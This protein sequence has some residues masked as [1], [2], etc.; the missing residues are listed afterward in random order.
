MNSFPY[1]EKRRHWTLTIEEQRALNLGDFWDTG[2]TPD[3]VY[4]GTYR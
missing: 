2:L 3:D 1:L 4:N